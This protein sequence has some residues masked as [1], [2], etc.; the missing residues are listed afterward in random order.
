[1]H[2]PHTFQ[3]PTSGVC[4]TSTWCVR[5]PTTKP[6]VP[7]A[8]PRTA[9]SAA[10]ASDAAHGATPCGRRCWAQVC[11]GRA[12]RAALDCHGLRQRGQGEA[13]GVS[14]RSRDGWQ[15][16]SCHVRCQGRQWSQPPVRCRVQ[17]P[18]PP[19]HTHTT[20]TT[21]TTTHYYT[22][23][24]THNRHDTH[25][26]AHTHTHTHTHTHQKKA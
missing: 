7:A 2:T 8:I 23:T 22:H 18:P 5:R 25:T 20:T 12:T 15:L 14:P 11:T 4:G 13:E 1:M 16:H 9:N 21:I 10:A 24:H 6:A 26:R 17:V 3:V 19:T